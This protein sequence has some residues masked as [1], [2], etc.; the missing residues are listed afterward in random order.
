MSQKMPSMPS[1]VR[2]RWAVVLSD[3]LFYDIVLSV[4]GFAFVGMLGYS[5][6]SNGGMTTSVKRERRVK[7]EE[8]SGLDAPSGECFVALR[9]SGDLYHCSLAA[10]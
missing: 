5:H 4:I 2:H 1:V 7:P 9:S 6:T 10:R 8:L 3:C